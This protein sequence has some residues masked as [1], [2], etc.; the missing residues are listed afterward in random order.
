[1][2]VDEL[3]AILNEGYVGPP[4]AGPAWREAMR[5]GVDMSLV[6][7]NLGRGEWERLV[8]HDQALELAQTLQAAHFVAG[9]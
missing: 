3:A 1:V 8:Q 2:S 9:A 4:D 5:Q 6:E 7:R